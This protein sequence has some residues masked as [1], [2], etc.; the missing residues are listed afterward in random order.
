MFMESG[1]R[2][3]GEKEDKVKGKVANLQYALRIL[4]YNHTKVVINN[5]FRNLAS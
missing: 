5:D 1:V 3:R 4:G 2:V